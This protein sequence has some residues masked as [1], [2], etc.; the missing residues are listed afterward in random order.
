MY[1]PVG[2]TGPRGRSI[3]LNWLNHDEHFDF[4]WLTRD[5]AVLGL[6]LKHAMTAQA[7]GSVYLSPQPPAT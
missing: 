7:P 2:Y 6:V 5:L 1:I 3:F 4:L